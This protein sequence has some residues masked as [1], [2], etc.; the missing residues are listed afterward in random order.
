MWL[1][2]VGALFGATLLVPV[3]AGA[4]FLPFGGKVITTSAVGI[5]CL[6]EGPITIRPV[7]LSPVT[8]YVITLATK[9]YLYRTP[10]H[11]A[12]IIG[13]YSPILAPL[14]ATNTT[15]PAPVP[16]F[17]IIFFGVSLPSL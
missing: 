9:R 16:A 17:P 13:L 5:T 3:R 4:I 15:P 14:C 2:V 6:G 1:L 8:P 10:V 7:G 12:W 11:G